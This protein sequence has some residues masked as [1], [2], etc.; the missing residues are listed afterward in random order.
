[1]EPTNAINYYKLYSVHKRT[2]SYSKAHTAIS[3][4]VELNGS[5]TDWRIQKA[6]LLV[7][8]GSCNEAYVVA[9]TDAKDG[10]GMM[11]GARE[12]NECAQRTQLTMKVYQ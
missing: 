4:A 10:N 6:K 8:L 7:S 11:N 12:G 1:M 9:K 5:K 3:T 2:R